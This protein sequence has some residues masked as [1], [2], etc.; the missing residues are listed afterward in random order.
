MKRV[1]V[2]LRVLSHMQI[3]AKGHRALEGDKYDHYLG[4]GPST[5]YVQTHQVIYIKYVKFFGIS[6]I[7]Q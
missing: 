7:P 1:D 3:K 6:I 4:S 5:T 2:M